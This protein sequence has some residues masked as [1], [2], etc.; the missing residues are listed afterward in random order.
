MKQPAKEFTTRLVH[1]TCCLVAA[2][3]CM[4]VAPLW[5]A[6]DSMNF[7]NQGKKLFDSYR[8][9]PEQNMSAGSSDRNLMQY[10]EL[11]QY[12]GSPPQIPHEVA[13]SFSG[14][15]PECLSC[16]A[17][18]GYSQEF[19]KFIPVT[20]HPEQV[21]CYQCHAK[22]Q[23]EKLF[24]ESK[25]QSIATP[26]LGR[27]FLSSS[28]PPIPHSLQLRENC[29]ACHTGPGAVAEIRVAHADRG[30]CRQ[31]HVPDVQTTPIATFTR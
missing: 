7:D 17:N 14:E 25:W 12:P 30:N 26:R 23:T 31:C 2:F 11:R 18:G 13:P 10:Y 20:P 8:A 15:E 22:P 4:T 3:L 16:H 29:I 24:V 9:T 6:G 1:P 28:P 5:A 19:G 21:L 27:S